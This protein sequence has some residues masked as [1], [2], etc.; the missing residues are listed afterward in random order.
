MKKFVIELISNRFGIVLAAL[1]LCYFASLGFD[2][3]GRLS[4]SVFASLNMPAAIPTAVTLLIGKL[5]IR[6][7]SPIDPQTIIALVFSFFI[8]L[9]WLFVAWSARRLAARFRKGELC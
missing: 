2:S 9:Q 3:I 1:N 8:A 4:G 6:D 7:L 5:F